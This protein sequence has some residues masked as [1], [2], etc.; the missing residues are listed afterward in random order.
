MR[1]PPDH[2]LLAAAV[3][4]LVHTTG[5]QPL[6]VRIGASLPLTE[7]V[8]RILGIDTVMFSFAVADENFHAPNEFFRLSSVTDGLAAW[9]RIIRQISDIAPAAFAPYRRE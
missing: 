2:P 7:I 3:A 6:K 9:V 8:H 1:V 5:Q 4:A